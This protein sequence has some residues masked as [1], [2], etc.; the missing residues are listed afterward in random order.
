MLFYVPEVL[1]SIEA[2]LYFIQQ[3]YFSSNYYSKNEG[4][5]S[6]AKRE[7]QELS[8]GVG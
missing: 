1:G 6:S 4:V 3:K 7:L 8:P 2:Q 5:N